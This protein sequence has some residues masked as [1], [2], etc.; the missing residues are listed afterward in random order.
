M[1]FFSMETVEHSLAISRQ[2]YVKLI[3]I[4]Q[5]KGKSIKLNHFMYM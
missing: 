5:T 2:D 3:C 4:F 1:R